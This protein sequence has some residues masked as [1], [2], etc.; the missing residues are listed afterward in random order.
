MRE[1]NKRSYMDATMGASTRACWY[2]GLR[3]DDRFT[4]GQSRHMQC[5]HRQFDRE[6]VL[7]SRPMATCGSVLGTRT[8]AARHVHDLR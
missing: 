4:F 1:Q 8:N 6:C 3:K 7:V 5:A 2:R